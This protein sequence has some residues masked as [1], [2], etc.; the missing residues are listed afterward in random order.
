MPSLLFLVGIGWHHL[1]FPQQY[2]SKFY[3][4]PLLLFRAVIVF[5]ISVNGENHESI[6]WEVSE[7]QEATDVHSY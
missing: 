6:Y 1:L 5:I 2:G 4:H 7:N 3:G